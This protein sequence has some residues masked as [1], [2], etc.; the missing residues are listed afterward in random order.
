MVKIWID[1]DAAPRDVKEIIFRAAR[2]LKVDTILVANQ[3]LGLPPNA[4]MVSSVTVSEGANEADKYIVEH[5]EVGDIVITADIPLAALL[6][7]KSVDAIDP[8]GEKYTADNIRTRLSVRD[9]MDD[10]RGAGAVTGGSRP[11]D[12]KD[13]KA[14]A[15][16]FDSTLTRALR[17]H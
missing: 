3:P 14:F 8:R 15:A 16:T 12:E 4:S 13:K 7:E 6:V 11:Y 17:K 1:A 10:M 5:A 9:F 2:R